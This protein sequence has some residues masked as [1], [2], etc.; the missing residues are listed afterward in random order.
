MNVIESKWKERKARVEQGIFF[1]TDE[2][3]ALR[4]APGRGYSV[5]PRAS[6]AS[7]LHSQPDSW[8]VLGDPTA[9]EVRHGDFSVFGG[10]TSWEAE[11]FIAVEQ[12][13][14]LLWLF[15]LAES[16]EFV[17]L[18]TDGISIVARSGGYQTGGGDGQIEGVGGGVLAGEGGVH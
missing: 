4:G 5:A 7:L 1:A 8:C 9:G 18:S 2:F 10:G 3:I 17:H 16:K 11:G 13:S 6:I 12:R 14:Q 15:H